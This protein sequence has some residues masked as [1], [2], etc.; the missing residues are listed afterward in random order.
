MNGGQQVIPVVETHPVLFSKGNKVALKHN[1]KQYLELF[2]L[3]ILRK[4]LL[5]SNDG[6]HERRMH[7]N[8][9]ELSEE[10]PLVYIVGD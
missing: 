5:R 8:W 3:A 2:F 7:L 9:L 10:D 1:C 4:D 6:I